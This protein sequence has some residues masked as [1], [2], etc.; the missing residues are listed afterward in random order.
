MSDIL[1]EAV[2]RVDSETTSE[3]WQE[4]VRSGVDWGQNWEKR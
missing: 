4:T 1:M 2:A 3:S